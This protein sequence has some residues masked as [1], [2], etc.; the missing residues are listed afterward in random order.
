MVMTP[1]FLYTDFMAD[2]FVNVKNVQAK[3]HGKN[4]QEMLRGI[5]FQLN[6]G[7]H[8]VVYGAPASGKSSLLKMLCGDLD[9]ISGTAVINGKN[10]VDDKMLRSGYVSL[11]HEELRSGKAVYENLVDF[12]EAQGIPHL[13][14]KIGALL[15]LLEMKELA[16]KNMQQL[17]ITQKIAYGIIRASL[18]DSPVLLL[19]DVV[20]MLGVEETK[21]FLDVTCTGRT[22]LLTTRIPLYAEQ[23]NV[24]LLILH[25]GT[26]AHAGSRDDI[27]V[28][29]GIPRVVDAWVEGLRYDML[30]KLRAHT[31]VLEVRILPTDRFEGNLVRISIR[32]SRFLP[33]LYDVMSQSELVHVEEVPPKLIDILRTI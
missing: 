25:N 13:P 19:D 24:P 33:S 22:V 28:A 9:I 1:L 2:T 10:V 8:V 4:T 14:A 12:G 16:T 3:Y 17:S 20:D 32:N 29:S 23:M 21:R 26:L 7:D 31:G 15:E 6:H 27:A 5:S 18:S 30:K 11:D